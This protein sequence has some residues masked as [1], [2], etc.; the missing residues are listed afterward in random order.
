MRILPSHILLCCVVSVLT[1]GACATKDLSLN[2]RNSSPSNDNFQRCEEWKRTQVSSQGLGWD[3]NYESVLKSNGFGPD[4]P[5]WKWI[6]ANGRR[7]PVNESVAG[8]QGE[9]IA[10]SML[11][12]IA[13]P[14]GH[15]GG[16]WLIRT[17]NHLYRWDFNKGIFEAQRQELTSLHEYDK[18]FES[19]ACW[20]Q[21]VP[22]KTDTFLEG[23]YGFLSLYKESKSRQML[24]TFRDF[25]TVDPRDDSKNL[26]DRK[27][28]GRVWETLEPVLPSI[29][30]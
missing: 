17:T 20:Q 10:S 24:L 26:G 19:I 27:N 3:L 15:P 8:W 11:I 30:E 21:G 28:W 6:H 23:Y 7:P 12:E 13:G 4:T 29:H 14:E 22:I 25:F 16:W 5:M 18:A 1:V 2:P 9:P